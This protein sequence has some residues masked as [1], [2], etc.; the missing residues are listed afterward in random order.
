MKFKLGCTLAYEAYDRA[1]FFFN[2]EAVGNESQTVIEERLEIDPPQTIETYVMPETGNRCLR[3]E[4]GPGPVTL[5]YEAIIDHHPLRLDA[6]DIAETDAAVLPPRVLPYLIPSRYCEADRLA[7]LATIEFGAMKRGHDRVTGICNWVYGQLGYI[8]GS[9]DLHTSTLDTL[10]D[11]AGVC[12]D[13]AHLGIALCR[14]LGIPA[15]YVSVYA[16]RLRPP[17]FHA[18]FEAYLG[19]RWYLFDPTRQAAIEGL[20][21]IGVGRDAAEVAFANFIG[22]VEPGDMKVFIEPVEPP[23][24]YVPTIDA[25]SVSAS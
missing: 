10:V 13:F 3:F 20:V 22:P 6:T 8:S 2:V 17:D 15:R 11:R 18:V 9:S 24:W 25:V 19:G 4:T 23:D 21:R 12:R 1:L 16:W 7:H 5:R 14:A